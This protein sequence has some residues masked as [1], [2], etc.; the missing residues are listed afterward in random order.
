QAPLRKAEHENYKFFL[1]MTD[2]DRTTLNL[3]TVKGSQLCRPFFEYSG[4]CAGCYEPLYV[5][6]FLQLYPYTI[7]SNA[8]GCSSIWGAQAYETPYSTDREGFGAAW[9]NP[10][11][12]NNAAVGGG[13]AL[14]VAAEETQTEASSRFV[15]EA[16]SKDSSLS[17]NKSFIELREQLEFIKESIS[18]E[19]TTLADRINRANNIKQV[20]RVV[21]KAIKQAPE[22]DISLKTHLELLRSTISSRLDKT[23][24]IVGG[25]GWAFDIGLQMLIHVLQSEL[26]VV[27][28]VLV[29]DAY[30]N[31]GG[32]M[33]KATPMG[34]DTPFAPGGK[35][36]PRYPLG[37]SV[38][39]GGNTFVGQVN[40]AFPNHLISTYKRAAEYKGPSLLLC[41]VPC[42]TEQKFHEELVEE[43]ARK[44]TTTRYW[45]L[46]DYD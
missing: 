9:V 45:P 35:D 39:H 10:L 7:I 8:T 42:M 6:K 25:D 15:L 19:G 37:M 17:K 34:M 5:S 24:L 43:Q 36:S 38:A 16:I 41:Y 31:T 33:S 40:L 21:G 18:A 13:I 23:T 11:F 3:S 30:S 1:D 44:A 2:L 29:T 28:M 26:N 22:D 27:V 32:Q 20:E 12:E 4:A 46:W 14:G